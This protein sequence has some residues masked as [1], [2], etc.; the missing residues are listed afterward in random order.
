MIRERSQSLQ[1]DA[2]K[3][4]SAL[5]RL[6]ELAIGL[7]LGFALEDSGLIDAEEP[8]EPDNAYARTELTQLRRRLAELT[9]RLPEGERRVIFRHYF[10]QLPFDEIAAGMNLTKGRI[11]QLHHAALRRLRQR[12]RELRGLGGEG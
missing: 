4:R 1:A 5:E 12:L 11:S 9:E 6:A 3:D 10:Q 2:P 8:A 7:A